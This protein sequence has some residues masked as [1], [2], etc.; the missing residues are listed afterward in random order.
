MY[1][2]EDQ[3]KAEGRKMTRKLYYEDTCRKEFDALATACEQKNASYM[4]TLDASAFYPEGG[5]QSGDRGILVLQDQSRVDVL[6]THEKGEDIV[7]TCSG[8]VP[9]GERVHG[10]LDWEF[11]FD[12]MQ[13][14][15]GEH[16]L[17]GLIHERYGYHNVGFHMSQDRV[18]IDLDGEIPPDELALIEKKANEIVW[19]DLPVCVDV[20]PQDQADQVEY[21][22]KKKLEGEIRLVT[23]PGADVCACC[24]TH[25][26]RTG[27]IGLI[28]ILSHER[29]RNGVRMEIMCGRW[30]YEYMEEIF[31]QNHEVSVHLSSRMHETGKAAQRLVEE[32]A[33][34]KGDLTGML[35]AQIDRM[36]R[37][38]EGVG[39]VLL[40]A[41]DSDSRIA[42]KLTAKVMETSGGSVFSFAG[43][44][45]NGYKYAAGLKD[46]D[47]RSLV[48]EMNLS[49]NGRGG[50]KPYFQQGSIQAGR[51]EIEAFLRER[52]PKMTCSVF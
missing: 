10:I 28:K 33:R 19:A 23:I 38:L 30:A 34:L 47:L 18:T 1:A 37:E 31:R 44:D 35:F 52:Y 27:E 13:N 36:A 22:S 11:R 41:P 43:S 5:G 26:T 20:L 42:M 32:N 45:E 15:T 46:G 49:L 40:F 39:D 51:A 14:H 9:A 8:P 12:R 29:F 16:I 25:V 50:G 17:S 3:R 2:H 7:L 48:K 21:R 24:G 4:V 6:D